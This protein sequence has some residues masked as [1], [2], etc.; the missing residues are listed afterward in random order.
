FVADTEGVSFLEAQVKEGTLTKEAAQDLAK[1]H[2]EGIRRYEASL[3]ANAQKQVETWETECRNH[4]D[5]GG[6]KLNA[7]VDNAKLVLQKYA[8]PEMTS[9][10]DK[11]GVLSHPDFFA[12]LNKIHAATSDGVSIGGSAGKVEN[13]PAKT[14]FPGYE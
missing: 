12:M 7:S 6:V 9:V 3:V 2:M 8:T 10:F 5:F 13:D 4:P 14:M 1:V 11:L